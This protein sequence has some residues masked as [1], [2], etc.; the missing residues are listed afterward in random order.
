VPDQSIKPTC[1]SAAMP[2]CPPN[3]VCAGAGFCYYPCTSLAE[4]VTFD[5]RFVACGASGYCEREYEVDP[6][7]TLLAPCP[8]GSNCVSNECE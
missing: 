1:G 5:A 3:A 7:C 6:Q 4:C 8:T 2:S